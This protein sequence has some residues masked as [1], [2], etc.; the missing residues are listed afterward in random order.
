MKGYSKPTPVKG[1]SVYKFYV[2]YPNPDGGK[3]LKKYFKTKNEA[4]IFSERGNIQTQSAGIT[5]ATL[6]EA[7]RRA[8]IDA[9][10]LLKPYA[11][12]VL[13]GARILAQAMKELAPYRADILQAVKHYKKWN[14]AQKDSI[15][16]EKAYE[17]YLDDLKAQGLSERHID[18]QEHRLKR[19][20]NDFGG[21][22]IVMLLE[23]HKIEKWIMGLK[24]FRFVED[25]K[26]EARPDGTRPKI[27]K[28]S[29]ENISPK[30][31]NNY[32]TSLLAFFSYCKRKGYVRDN[33]IERVAQV[34][35]AA[36]EP[37]IYT[38]EE[39]RA[40]LN[41][42]PEGSDIRA[43][44]AIAAFAGLRR[45]ELERLTWN[46]VDLGDKTITLE[47]AIVKTGRRRIVA[48]SDN[49]AQWLLPYSL[50]TNTT[51]KV[52]GDN[53]GNRLA[54]FVETN[55]ITWKHNALRHSSASYYLAL[56]GDEYK[57]AAQMGHSVNVLRTNY[58]GLVKPKDA[59]AYWNIKPKDNNIIV[60]SE[61]KK[62]L[63]KSV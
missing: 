5:I 7:H 41:A 52:L 28:E 24:A 10:N 45:A 39:L 19:F 13:D 54:R 35:E 53:F 63:K 59:K 21:S 9:M 27:Q 47:G 20:V 11:I 38:V 40:M 37:E 44:I 48:I 26:A 51:E 6:P 46:R 62:P 4:T 58:K 12:S 18:S 14:E 34:K 42:S 3:R 49:L 8:Y 60:F 32:R 17:Q 57:T 16:L 61:L 29:K 50:K 31:K 2:Y 36:K 30:T 22:H 55:G 43:Y 1:N 33:P 25:K 56:I 15:T 23:A